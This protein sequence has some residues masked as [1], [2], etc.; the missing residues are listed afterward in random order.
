LQLARGLFI[1]QTL[2]TAQIRAEEERTDGRQEEY[3]RSGP[4]CHSPQNSP[5]A[6][7]TDRSDE[8]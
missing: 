7:A 5:P 4:M 2:V 1:R 8:K 3:E 6:Q